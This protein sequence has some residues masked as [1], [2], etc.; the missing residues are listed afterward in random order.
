MT[1]RTADELE[2]AE[3]IREQGVVDGVACARAELVQT[4]K[5]FDGVHCIGC[6]EELPLVRIAYKRIRCTTCQ[7]EIERKEKMRRRA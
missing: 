7:C 3:E 2:A 5:D 1:E 6:G 4:H